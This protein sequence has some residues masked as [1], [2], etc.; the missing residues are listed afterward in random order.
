MIAA[1]K[2][3]DFRHTR[4]VDAEFP[5]GIAQLADTITY[6]S[7]VKQINPNPALTPGQAYYFLEI[8]TRDVSWVPPGFIEGTKTVI[9]TDPPTLQFYLEFGTKITDDE[10]PDDA[11]WFGPMEE[12][13][14]KLESKAILVPDQPELNMLQRLIGLD[15]DGVRF[16]IQVL[17]ND[18]MAEPAGTQFQQLVR[19]VLGLFDFFRFEE[20]SR[21]EVNHPVLGH[22]RTPTRKIHTVNLR[23]G[24]FR[25][26]V[27]F[28][29]VDA[30]ERAVGARLAEG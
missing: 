13:L 26:D 28:L 4:H 30:R 16:R 25:A 21:D 7:E 2:H 12:H 27:G 24:V 19:S 15:A 3:V 9:E 18:D 14:H 10:L 11:L 6:R 8:V 29:A 5:R 23:G 20:Q 22:I 17:S 1:L